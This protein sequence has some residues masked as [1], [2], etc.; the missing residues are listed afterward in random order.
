MPGEKLAPSLLLFLA[1]AISITILP[2]P[3]VIQ[4][5]SIPSGLDKTCLNKAAQ[6][7]FS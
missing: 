6:K 2:V 1:G 3:T 7:A 5:R 4:Q